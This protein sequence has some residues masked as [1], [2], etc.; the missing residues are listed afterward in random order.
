MRTVYLALFTICCILSIP[1]GDTRLFEYPQKQVSCAQTFPIETYDFVVSLEANEWDYVLSYGT[2]GDALYGVFDVVPIGSP[3]DF[4]ICDSDNL[5]EWI[6]GNT[7]IERYTI[8]ENRDFAYWEFMPPYDELWYY[9]FIND[10]DVSIDVWVQ[11]CFDT[12]A[13]YISFEPSP[14]REYPSPVDIEIR[15]S[16]IPYN[17]SYCSVELY[18]QTLVEEKF[19]SQFSYTFEETFTL[20]DLEGTSGSLNLTGFVNDTAGNGKSYSYKIYI[21]EAI[22]PTTS[23]STPTTDTSPTRPTEPNY[24]IFVLIGGAGAMCCILMNIIQRVRRD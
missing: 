17:L 16:D 10:E 5:Q 1:A 3:I 9:V 15:F 2:Y 6:A 8:Y 18:G 24:F 13:P 12:E 21:V 14:N 23:V 19:E 4:F 22:S 20:E 7:S 11:E